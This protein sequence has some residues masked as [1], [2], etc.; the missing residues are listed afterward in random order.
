MKMIENQ[1]FRKWCRRQSKNLSKK[2][3]SALHE[4]QNWQPTKNGKYIYE[5]S[6]P[7]SKNNPHVSLNRKRLKTS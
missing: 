5:H 2:I 7:P 4:L 6:R 1:A 3:H